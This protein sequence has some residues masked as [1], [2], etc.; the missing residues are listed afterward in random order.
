MAIIVM[1]LSI[2]AAQAAPIYQQVRTGFRTPLQQLKMTQRPAKPNFIPVPEVR[3][4]MTRDKQQWQVASS[5]YS[6]SLRDIAAR[7]AADAE[8]PGAEDK[9]EAAAGGA[10]EGYVNVYGEKLETCLP[11]TLYKEPDYCTYR[12]AKDAVHEICVTENSPSKG[13]QGWQRH[14][15]RSLQCIRIQD[16]DPF[17]A[18][19][20]PFD[21]SGSGGRRWGGVKLSDF[22]PKCNA[23]PAGVLESQWSMDM[24]SGGNLATRK[25]TFVSEAS[26]KYKGDAPAQQSEVVKSDSPSAQKVRDAVE[27]ICDICRTQTAS[28]TAK[29]T[30][31]EKCDAI[32]KLRPDKKFEPFAIP[33]KKRPF[34]KLEAEVH[35]PFCGIPALVLIALLMMGSGIAMVVHRLR[36]SARTAAMEQYIVL[37]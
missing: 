23:L 19:L 22:Y 34:E 3:S 14:Y 5:S 37:G 33:Q 4:S 35:T 27:R 2:L 24:V 15:D 11:A 9:D 12:S 17:A 7:A 30:L 21:L 31:G 25:L 28:E 10:K 8:A 13:R 16:L 18:D 32:L 26:S 6:E 20:A 36:H 29:A 1:M